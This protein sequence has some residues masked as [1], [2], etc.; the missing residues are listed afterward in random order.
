MAVICPYVSLII[1]GFQLQIVLKSCLKYSVV[2]R[3][4]SQMLRPP[5]QTVISE[6]FADLL[7]LTRLEIV[8]D[9]HQILPVSGGKLFQCLIIKYQVMFPLTWLEILLTSCLK[10]PVFSYKFS[11]HLIKNIIFFL[12]QCD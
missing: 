10:Y 12:P 4:V 3:L 2:S 5:S 6:E 9:S 8:P 1:S 7:Q 11:Q